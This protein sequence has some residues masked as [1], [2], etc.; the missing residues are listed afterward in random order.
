MRSLRT[1]ALLALATAA[2]HV[3]AAQQATLFTQVRVFDGTRALGTRDVLVRD[4]RIAQ[5]AAKIATPAGAAVVDGVGKT[6]LPGLIDSHVHAWGD[7]PKTALA[8]GVTTELD[9]FTDY[10]QAA[11]WRAEQKGAGIGT[12]ADVFSAGTLVTA[13][14]GHGT[15]YGMPIPTITSPDSAQAFVDARMAEGS[16]W[17]KIVYDDGHTY[18]M[19]TPT[20]SP[21]T[22]QA[23]VRAA[24]ARGKLAVVHVGDLAGARAAIDAGA[25][26]L[27]HLFVDREPD[28]EFAHFAAQHHVFVVPTLTVLESVTGT[29]SGKPLVSDVR[30]ASYILPTDV[31]ALSQS[32]P[33]REGAPATTYAAAQH[34]VRAL[35]AAGVPLLAGTDA[36]NPGTAHG[37]SIHRELELLVGAGLTP[38]A[39]LAAATRAPADAFRLTDRGRIVVGARADLLLV[40]GDPTTDITA[41]RAIAGVWKRGVALDRVGVAKDV[42]AQRGLATRPAAAVMPGLVSD[43]DSGKPTVAYGAGWAVTNDAMRGGTS[44]AKMDVVAGGAQGTAYALA[45]SGMI[46]DKLPYAWAGVMLSPASQPFTP[47]NLS[48]AKA[49]RFRVRGDGKGGRVMLFSQSKGFVPIERTFA[50]SSEWTEIVMPFASFDGIDGHDV[51]SIIFSGGPAAGAFAF[52]LDDVRI[53]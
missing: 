35:A 13:P 51:L 41:T 47:A 14:K 31:T 29:P 28:T 33:K 25:D 37:S 19:S 15:E 36:G 8:F 48:A 38:I 10:H 11:A 32:F 26:A 30:L 2:P 22:M 5:I 39:A 52:Q 21:A 27:V 34:A 49:L 53:Q 3:V 50:T 4:G 17:I 23:V 42:A 16:D 12:R 7:A 45:V 24:H 18:G 9:Q 44:T 6:L 46:S 1:F 43:F 20:I 40:N